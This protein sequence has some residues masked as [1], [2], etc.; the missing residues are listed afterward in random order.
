MERK[1]KLEKEINA[2]NSDF[3]RYYE[4]Y[5]TKLKELKDLQVN[6]N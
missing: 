5:S 3:D 1:K 4:I 2:L 6:M